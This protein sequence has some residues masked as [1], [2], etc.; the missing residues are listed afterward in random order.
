MT[1]PFTVTVTDDALNSVA[2]GFIE[3][4]LQLTFELT[5]QVPEL[6]TTLSKVAGT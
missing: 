1:S 5:V 6:I 2:S 4:D 3:T